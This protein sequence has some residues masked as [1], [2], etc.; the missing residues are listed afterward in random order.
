MRI[1]IFAVLIAVLSFTR[2]GAS[3]QETWEPPMPDR[4]EITCATFSEA[5]LLSLRGATRAEVI[6]AMNAQGIQRN[7]NDGCPLLHYVSP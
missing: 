1:A 4:P 6:K 3:C 2:A 5:L 7:R